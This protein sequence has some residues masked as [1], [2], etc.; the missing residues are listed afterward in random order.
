MSQEH[1][2]GPWTIER[3][4]DEP[5]TYVYF[6]APGWGNFAQAVVRMEDDA[7]DSP[8]GLANARLIAAAP[9]LLEACKLFMAYDAADDDNG[10]SMML[11]YDKARRAALG[12]FVKA[13]GGLP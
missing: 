1:T 2:P 12:A 13:T 4:E 7:E 11:A 8:T 9:E 5:D 6:Q 3:Y 10:V